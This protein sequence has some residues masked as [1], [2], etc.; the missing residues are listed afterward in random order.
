MTGEARLHDQSRSAGNQNKG[1][2]S[3]SRNPSTNYALAVAIMICFQFIFSHAVLAEPQSNDDIAF[4]KAITSLPYS[5]TADTTT[6]TTAADDP[7][8]CAWGKGYSSV[9]YTF[10]PVISGP[11]LA[12]T[13]GS[14]YSTVLAIWQGVPGSLTQAACGFGSSLVATLTAGTDYY[15]E[16][17]GA[18]TGG[19]LKFAF[20]QLTPP[21]N[22]DFDA[23]RLITALPYVDTQD[24]RGGSTS[25]DDPGLCSAGKGYASVWYSYTP[26]ADSF[27]TATTS[28]SGY[29]TVLA[30]WTGVRGSLQRVACDATSAADGRSLVV[31]PLTAGTTYHIEVAGVSPVGTA[32][33]LTL[34]VTTETPLSV[35]SLGDAVDAPSLTW[36]SGGNV[37]WSRETIDFYSDG[38]A[39]MSGGV[40]SGQTSWIA[41]TV[42][43]PAIVSFQWKVSGNLGF[44][45]NGAQQSRCLSAIWERKDLVIPAGNHTFLWVYTSSSPSGAGLLDAF[46]VTPGPALMLK[47]PAGGEEW[48][49]RTLK[50]VSWLATEDVGPVK[51]ELLKGLSLRLLIADTTPN[52]GAHG[53]WVP[54]G[55][56]P[57]SDYRIKLSSVATPALSDMSANYFSIIES[58][59]ALNGFLV[60]PTSESYV[61]APHGSELDLGSSTQ[62]SF[63]IEGWLYTQRTGWASIV[64]KSGSYATFIRMDSQDNC[65]GWSLTPPSGSPVD[66]TEV[67]VWH[68]LP[69]GSKIALIGWHHVALVYDKE[70]GGVL[71]LYVNGEKWSE[72]SKPGLA[73]ANS[74]EQLKMGLA[75]SGALDEVRISSAARYSGETFALPAAPFVCDGNTRA[76]WHFDEP[77]GATVFHDS[78]G[79][80][81]VLFSF[82]GAHT[83]GDLNAPPLVRYTLTLAQN[84]TGSGAVASSPPGILCGATCSSQFDKDTPVTLFAV[85]SPGSV[86]AGWSGEGCSGTG[87]CTVMMSQARNVTAIFNVSP[88]SVDLSLSKTHAGN[89]LV[90]TERAY[91]L[92]ISNVRSEPTTGVITVTDTLPN[93]LSYVSGNGTGWTCSDAGQ[94]VTC[95]NP[96]PIAAGGSST[97][98]LTVEVAASAVPMVTNTAT[99]LVTG[100]VNP[101][102]NTAS[103]PTVCILPS[104]LNGDS[105]TDIVWR[106][107]ATGDINVWFMNGSTVMGDAWLPRVASQQWQIVGIGDFDGDGHADVLWRYALTGD[108]NLWFMDGVMVT[109]DAWLPRVSDLQWQ[110]AGIGDFNKDGK[111]DIVWRHNASGD[112][113]VWFMNG[114]TVTSDAWLPR[115]ADP[116]WKIAGIGDFNGDGGGDIV[117]RYIPSGDIDVWLMNGITVT[118]DAWLPRV[119]DPQWQMNAIGDFNGDGNAE[120]VWRHTVSGDLNIWFMN[121][122]SFVSDGWLPRVADQQW[123]IFGPR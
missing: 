24:T 40:S 38:D 59:V 102:N 106:N 2:I 16:V 11:Y 4:A 14:N 56:E 95:T 92:N 76:L 36:L 86:F 84:G 47:T 111:S 7:T 32:G 66:L 87:T 39:A 82:S 67:C 33:P 48:Y 20:E 117:W 70:A 118:S 61:W 17:A 123:K 78:C 58:G 81:N 54:V 88:G 41:T 99:V 27:L 37:V 93:G 51:V 96:G 119:A 120:I 69:G 6:A 12:K 13:L 46:T 122:V 57:A 116:Q 49:T 75:L 105:R 55:L 5:D 115:V 72:N 35:A 108:M 26:T 80:D 45:L 30:V 29:S 63:T 9:W 77:T 85:A 15:I 43:G 50:S 79:T 91:T 34:T 83:D 107:A 112:I 21:P 89:F 3:M 97:I 114:G 121:G 73:L 103:N 53:W 28:G 94:T 90:G 104:D 65:V 62:G 8:L 18:S 22:D 42:A 10:H 98:T 68:Y 25:A 1:G 23:A 101:A 109:S 110:I 31:V 19:S 113:N 52:D 100:D 64:S 74:L 60:L 71:R 44:Y